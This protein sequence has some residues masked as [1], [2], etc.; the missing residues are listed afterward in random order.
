MQI[1]ILLKREYKLGT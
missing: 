1:Q